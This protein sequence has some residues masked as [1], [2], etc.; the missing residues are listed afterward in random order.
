MKL[1]FISCTLYTF[2][3]F[4][5]YIRW[6]LSLSLSLCAGIAAS[7]HFLHLLCS[8]C[9]WRSPA[10][11]FQWNVLSTVT[12]FQT[13]VA[14]KVLYGAEDD[15]M[16]NERFFTLILVSVSGSHLIPFRPKSHSTLPNRSYLRSEESGSKTG[17]Y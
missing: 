8:V 7:R 3:A 17:P 5:S 6:A 9:P 11:F 4:L 15:R 14:N 16:C 13:T 10:A 2:G 1:Y 12:A